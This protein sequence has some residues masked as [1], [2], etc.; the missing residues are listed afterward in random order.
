MSRVRYFFDS[1]VSMRQFS[2]GLNSV[3][4]DYE[5][6]D[7][8][9]NFYPYYRLRF[10]DIMMVARTNCHGN[11][12]CLIPVDDLMDEHQRIAD[13]LAALVDTTM[14]VEDFSLFGSGLPWATKLV[15]D[16]QH[17]DTAERWGFR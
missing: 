7:S 12:V 4:I 3:H 15:A 9:N 17:E 14:T 6:D 13:N 10:G 11:V 5:V 2:A 1:K 16:Q 8:P